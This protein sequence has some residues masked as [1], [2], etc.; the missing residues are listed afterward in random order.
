MSRRYVALTRAAE[1]AFFVGEF[2]HEFTAADEADWV[3][4]GA[5]AIVP[6]A[7]RVLVDTPVF[8]VSGIDDPP[9]FEAALPLEQEQQLVGGGH[10]ELV[11]EPIEEKKTRRKRETADQS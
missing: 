8:G 7:Y 9:T 11:A 6:C 3:A 2:E 1:A 4:R 5:I 10:I